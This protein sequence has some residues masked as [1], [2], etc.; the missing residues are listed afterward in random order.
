MIIISLYNTYQV[1]IRSFVKSKYHVYLLA[2][3]NI[4]TYITKLHYM[5]KFEEK[6]VTTPKTDCHVN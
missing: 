3:I 2:Y 1:I 6:I 4:S 5:I